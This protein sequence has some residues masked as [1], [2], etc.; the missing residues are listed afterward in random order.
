MILKGPKEHAEKAAD[1]ALASLNRL[2][3][4]YL[5][6]RNYMKQYH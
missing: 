3:L 2:G 1:A 6:R 4:E 5:V